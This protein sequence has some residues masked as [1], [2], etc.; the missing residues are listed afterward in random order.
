MFQFLIEWQ[1]YRYS[2]HC[3]FTSLKYNY[4]LLKYIIQWLLVYLH[5]YSHHYY[6]II[7]H[8]YHPKNKL[9]THE[10]SLSITTLHQP[11]TTTNLL[12]VSMNLLTLDSHIN[13]II[14]YVSYS[15]LFLRFI[16]SYCSI[17]QQFIS[18]HGR[19]LCR[20]LFTIC[21]SIHQLIAIWT[22]STFSLL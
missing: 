18:F 13:G 4:V 11:L 22:V 19:I 16:H 2:L 7:E 3:E 17:Y 12:S 21:I 5:L 6:L 8:L 10:K 9:C 20:C 15:M 14:Y 1:T